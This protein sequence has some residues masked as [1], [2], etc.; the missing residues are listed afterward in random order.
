LVIEVDLQQNLEPIT[1]LLQLHGYEVLVEQD[2][3]LRKT[4]LCYVYAIRP[5]A[6]GPRLIQNQPSN[7]HL[8]SLPSGCENILTPAT[9]RKHL[10]D[11][12]PQYMIPSAFVLMKEFP[13]TSNGK[14]DRNA[15][16]APS[17]DKP[18]I[19]HD[20]VMPR[21]ET[22]KALA[23]IWTDLLKVETIGINDDFFES[24][25]H[26][27]LSIR[28]ISRIR[29]VFGVDLSLRDLFERPTVVGLANAIDALTWLASSGRPAGG[30]GNREEIEL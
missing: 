4:P 6:T 18:A 5:S 28:A 27:L 24:G 15:L 8:R 30:I 10:R 12:L 3:L 9:L 20:L 7:S 17:S 29:D 11:R 1:T 25:G 14:I 22:E 16:P 13:L 21:T 26:S 19:S 2:P 23:T